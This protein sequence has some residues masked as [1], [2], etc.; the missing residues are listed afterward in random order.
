MEGRLRAACEGLSPE[1][2]PALIAQVKA[3]L[4]QGQDLL[5]RAHRE[6][7]GGL[8]L[9]WGRTRFMDSV[10]GAL[11]GFAERSRGEA[12]ARAPCAM[13]AV[14]GYG[15]G[16]LSP[17]SDVDLLFVFPRRTAALE[18][19]VTRVLYLLW[20]A[21]LDI[22]YSA[23]TYAE[24]IKM[25]RADFQ[26]ETSMLE[27]RLV[28]GDAE[29]Y[30][31]FE[32]RFA[33]HLRASGR[34]SYLNRRLRER[35]ERYQLWDPSVYVQEPNV[36]ESAGGLRDFHLMLWAGRA[37]FGS[38]ELADLVREGLLSQEDAEEAQ[39]AYDFLLRVRNELHLRARAK[40][41]VLTFDAQAEVAPALGYCN[42]ES[43]TAGERL[44][45]QYFLRARTLSQTS[46][47]F[48]DACE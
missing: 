32:Q 35:N 34:R 10:L 15:R 38:G 22:G 19:W 37:L 31:E 13:V 48:L 44:M 42:E 47:V 4:Q 6:G 25:A 3:A 40:R 9:V 8:A 46:R 7:A 2:R 39:A 14:G 30:R 12:S 29:A 41:E 43:A 45:R 21:G 17:A 28:A 11:W 18:A 36:K 26:S 5:A 33:E 24:C 1:A 20:D 23:R 16:E 27:H